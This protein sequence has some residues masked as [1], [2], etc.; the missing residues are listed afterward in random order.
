MYFQ[1]TENYV[2][3][4]KK[5]LAHKKNALIKSQNNIQ[6]LQQEIGDCERQQEKGIL[7]LA[8]M[9]DGAEAVRITIS[10]LSNPDMTIEAR[11]GVD[12]YLKK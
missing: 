7:E 1:K 6:K 9:A 10:E 2:I 4:N 11:R 3:S 8:L 5:H 12:N